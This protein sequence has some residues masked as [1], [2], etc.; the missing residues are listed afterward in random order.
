MVTVVTL[1][2]CCTKTNAQVNII[3]DS[4]D[5]DTSC[6]WINLDLTS[7]VYS[8]GQK[9]LVLWGDATLDT[10]YAT[11]VAGHGHIHRYHTYAL[12]GTY[13]LKTVLIDANVHV[14]SSNL[15]YTN[16]GCYHMF[17]IG[18]YNDLNNNCLYDIGDIPNYSPLTIQVDSNNIPIDTVNT[19][20]LN[21]Y[22][23]GAPGTIYKYTVIGTPAGMVVTCPATGYILD[24]V[25]NQAMQVTTKYFGVN[26]TAVPV[27]DLAENVSVCV[28]PYHGHINIDLT[29]TDCNGTN[30]TLVVSL[31]P[32]LPFS[33]SY[34]APTTIVGN[35]LTYNLTVAS[36][37]PQYITIVVDSTQLPILAVGDTFHTSYYLTPTAN[38]TDTTNNVVV[39]IDTVHAA[40]DPNYK[41]VMPKG[42]IQPGTMLTYT[43]NFE[44]TGNDTAHTIYVLDTLSDNLDPN[45]FQLVTSTHEVFTQVIAYGASHHLIRFNFPNIM[46]PDSSHHGLCDGM[47]VYK[48]RAKSTLVPGTYIPNDAGIYFDYNPVVMTNEVVNKIPIPQG[49]KVLNT[50][51]AAIYPNPVSDILTITT[52]ATAYNTIEISNT[53]GQVMLKEMLSQNDT[54]INVKALPAGIYFANLKGEGGSRTIKFEKL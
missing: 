28:S 44:N 18:S 46:L 4:I 45:S 6:S 54:K 49:I 5:A 52:D 23:L 42:D 8:V 51:K 21:I 48:I 30:A 10:V 12:I 15:S 24:T 7:N 35:T 14:D 26:C 34:P 41:D 3:A 53:I 33:T 37:Y 27:F 25:S 32:N 2:I 13:T 39:R 16:N 50:T 1:L 38:D 40:F 20:G 11:N 43:I 29:N 22:Q 9:V 17:T 47:F 36:I 31:S 19:P